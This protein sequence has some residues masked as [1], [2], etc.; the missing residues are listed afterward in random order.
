MGRLTDLDA[1]R[2]GVLS[3]GLVFGVALLIQVGLCADYYFHS[4]FYSGLICDAKIYYQWAD[5]IRQGNWFGN[6]VF[7]QAPLYPYFIAL[8]WSLFG[9][10]YLVIYAGQALLLALSVLLVFLISRRLFGNGAGLAAALVGAFYGSLNFYAL[11]ILPDILGVGLH[12]GL[13]YLLLNAVSPRQWLASGF[14]G[15]LLIIARPHAF[16][17][18]P[19]VLLWLLTR[20]QAGPAVSLKQFGLFLLP[21]LVLVGLVTLRNCLV[22]PGIVPVSSNGGENFF[23]GNNPR[24]D[25][26]Y[27]RMD[28]ISPDIEYQKVDVKKVA[29]AALERELTGAEVSRY[30]LG[31]GLKFIRGN[32]KAW[33][34]LETIKFKRVFSG[35]EYTNM[36]FLWFERAEFTRTLAVHGKKRYRPQAVSAGFSAVG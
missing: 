5:N 4:P 17:L 36:Y 7:H 20:G 3:G 25:G 28:G 26:I 18:L 27:C 8:L 9:R 19:L 21:V 2:R 16:L 13:V 31:Q 6:E 10:H 23:M 33:L 34:R 35:T 22:E 30:W 29:A 14:V 12:L 1:R 11:K 15:G 32:F 24:A